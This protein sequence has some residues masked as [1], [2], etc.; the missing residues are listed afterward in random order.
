MGEDRETRHGELR[1]GPR[2]G[3]IH[4]ET[5][6]KRGITMTIARRGEIIQKQREKM[7]ER[8]RNR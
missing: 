1:L 5:G 3:E 6:E 7:L 2:G 8:E 4:R